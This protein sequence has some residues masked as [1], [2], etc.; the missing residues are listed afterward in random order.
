MTQTAAKTPVLTPEQVAAMEAQ[1][2]MVEKTIRELSDGV[3]TKAIDLTRNYGSKRLAI[4]AS[5]DGKVVMEKGPFG[6]EQPCVLMIDGTWQMAD[7]IN[8][9]LKSIP[10]AAKFY[11]WRWEEV[12]K[13]YVPDRTPVNEKTGEV[14]NEGTFEQYVRRHSAKS[15]IISLPGAAELGFL[16]KVST[17]IAKQIKEDK[18]KIPADAA[19]R[20]MHHV[21]VFFKAAGLNTEKTRSIVHKYLPEIWEAPK[22]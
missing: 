16:A 18:G 11:V 7:G 20:V 2:L 6:N 22:K 10:G 17:E 8:S 9:K 1:K 5:A 4:I 15:S 14:G 19:D 3:D 21:S 12:F 13:K